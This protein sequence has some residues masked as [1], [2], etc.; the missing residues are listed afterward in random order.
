MRFHV[1]RTS[2]A[3]WDSANEMEFSSLEEL[4]AFVD[5]KEELVIVHGTVKGRDAPLLEIYDR[6]RE[7]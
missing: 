4:V 5:A 1:V 2:D 3:S 6:E 7:S